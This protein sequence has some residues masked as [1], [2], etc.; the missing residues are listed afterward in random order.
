LQLFNTAV[1]LPTLD[2][3]TPRLLRTMLT[4]IK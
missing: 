1:D 2:H 3:P 4:L